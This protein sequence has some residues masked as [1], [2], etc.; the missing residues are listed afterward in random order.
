MSPVRTFDLKEVIDLNLLQDIQEKFAELTG[1]AFVTVDFKGTPITSEI[2]FS[3]FCISRR[4]ISVYKKSCY[5]SDAHAGLEA[6]RRGQPCV[7]RCPAGLIDFAVPIVVQGQY[8]G[9]VLSGQVRCQQ[10]DKWLEENEVIK[11]DSKWKMNQEWTEKYQKTLHMDY[12]KII[13]SSQLVHLVINQLVEK[14]II[15]IIQ[16]ELNKNT[17][18]LM[19]E[20]KARAELAEKLRI[21]ELKSLKAQMNPHFL[22]NILNSIGCS[23]L[24]EGAKKTQEMTYMLSQLLRYNISGSGKSVTLKEDLQ[25]IERYLKIQQLR[26]GD[27]FTYSIQM[28][29]EL[30]KQNLPPLIIQP[31]IENA[32]QHGILPK[33]NQGHLDLQ[34]YI[35]EN[36][37]IIKI[38]DDGIG[39]SPQKI[40][41]L[42]GEQ[43]FEGNPNDIGI[44]NTR[45]RLIQSFGPQYDVYI[46]SRLNKGTSVTIKIPLDF[47]ERT[48]SN[49]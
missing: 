26:F 35:E 19:E 2:N 7:Y 40:N 10:N 25:N 27:K 41:V 46:E 29:E 9:A 20:K 28:P 21:A 42:L 8:L 6:A 37:I 44:Q 13:S 24:T 11:Y 3:D 1:L 47:E 45:K 22:F 14:E 12:D 5:M 48:Y 17:V 39:I 31:F 49:V 33:E 16:E 18:H 34:T 30:G 23:A 4:K 36:D 32:I 43:K 15:N 38:K